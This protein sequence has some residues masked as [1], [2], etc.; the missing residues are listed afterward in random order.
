MT[1]SHMNAAMSEI[2]TNIKR[3]PAHLALLILLG[4]AFLPVVDMVLHER[5]LLP[6]LHGAVGGAVFG[7]VL[8]AG[9]VMILS[10]N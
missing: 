9:I 8:R 7:I 5:S 4:A 2:W 3:T 1:T 10:R 6:A